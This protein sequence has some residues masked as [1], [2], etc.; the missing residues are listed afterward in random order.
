MQ[1]TFKDYLCYFYI[2][3]PMENVIKISSKEMQLMSEEFYLTSYAVMV[4]EW[5]FCFVTALID[6]SI[7]Y[8]YL[9][10][11]RSPELDLKR[12]RAMITKRYIND[13]LSLITDYY[14]E[15]LNK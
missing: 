4:I 12:N 13:K 7:I 6:L 10:H 3:E 9:C 11:D 2:D 8:V 15:K 1:Y 14:I 5:W